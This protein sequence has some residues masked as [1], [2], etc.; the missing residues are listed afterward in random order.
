MLGT[1]FKY[2]LLLSV[3]FNL[4]TLT[5]TFNTEETIAC[6]SRSK[7]ESLFQISF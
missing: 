1:N 2:I 6:F 3:G 7:S 5:L 4:M